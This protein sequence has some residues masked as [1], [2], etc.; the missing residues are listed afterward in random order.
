MLSAQPMG[1]QVRDEG[2]SAPSTGGCGSVGHSAATNQVAFVLD[3]AA[4]VRRA[5]VSDRHW[6]GSPPNPLCTCPAIAADTECLLLHCQL[7][8]P[9][10]A[11]PNMVGLSCRH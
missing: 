10:A 8:Q 11:A 3:V 1:T 2:P 4:G 5:W 6:P 9:S 7:T